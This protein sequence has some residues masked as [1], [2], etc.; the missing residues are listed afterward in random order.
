MTNFKFVNYTKKLSLPY[1]V[2]SSLSFQESTTGQKPTTVEASTLES[3]LPS[4]NPH[5]SGF[6]SISTPIFHLTDV[7]YGDNKLITHALKYE[8]ETVNG[9][10]LGRLSVPDAF[11]VIVD[12]VPLRHH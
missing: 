7:A 8:Q 4:P 9:V 2:P 10:L 11:I 12:A 3:T 6:R 1:L 5:L